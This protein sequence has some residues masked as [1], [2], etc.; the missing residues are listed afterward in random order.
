MLNK[1][2]LFFYLCAR[3]EKFY[4]S[5]NSRIT[6]R[7]K[8]DQDP[9]DPF[10]TNSSSSVKFRIRIKF[11]GFKFQSSFSV[12]QINISDLIRLI[13]SSL[14]R[15]YSINIFFKSDFLL[16]YIQFVILTFSYC[17]LHM[18]KNYKKFNIV[19]ILN[20]MN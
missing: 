5:F 10:L 19:K 13:C 1:K 8:L 6:Q 11:L 14:T 16:P 20:K 12:H 7:V 2:T 15:A 4:P 9:I 18:I 17:Y 3:I